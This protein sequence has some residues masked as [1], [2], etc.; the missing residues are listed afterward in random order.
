MQKICT[1]YAKKRLHTYGIRLKVNY[2]C[3]FGEKTMVGNFCHFNGIS[4]IGHGFLKIGDFFHSGAEILVITS[5]HDYKSGTMIPYNTIDI[6]KDVEIGD[7]VWVG[8]KVIILPGTKIEEG[9]IIQAGS[10][11]HGH[12][13]RCS[14]IGGNPAKKFGERDKIKFDECKKNKNILY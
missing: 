5:N 10:V 2:P 9:C 13:K 3:F 6:P 8:S 11:V 12:F 1:V 4:V 7:F 14:I